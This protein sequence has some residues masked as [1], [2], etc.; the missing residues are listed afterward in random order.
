MPNVTVGRENSGDIRIYYEDHGTGVPVVLISG[1]LAD[2]HAWEKQEPDLLN[3]GYRVITYDRRGSGR[4]S[5]PAAGYGYDTLAADLGVLLEALDVEDAILVG[6]CSGTGEVIRYLANHGSQRVRAAVLI[7]PLQPGLPVS[8]PDSDP[9]QDDRLFLN[10]L[11]A[12]LADDRPAAIKKFLDWS[13]NL[14]VLGGWNVSDQAWQNSFQVAVAVSAAAALGCAAAWREDFRADL[15]RIQ[16]PILVV[17]GLQDRVM[18]PAAAGHLL[19]VA[20][21]NATLVE[22]AG[23]PHA[24]IWTHSP[25]VNQ[26]LLGFLR[27]LEE[28]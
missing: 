15:G 5:R 18:P 13:Y 17:Q 20:L 28:G 10:K 14:D 25:E 12:A 8:A 22:I 4:S 24:V 11:L 7:S 16:I 27:G 23:G 3:A 21:P 2:A 19:A 26:A 6:S 9:D 1:F